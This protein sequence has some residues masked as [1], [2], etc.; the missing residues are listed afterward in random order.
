MSSSITSN[1]LPVCVHVWEVMRRARR[2][3][4]NPA[5]LLICS[6]AWQ[7]SSPAKAVSHKNQTLSQHI[8]QAGIS[9]ST[10]NSGNHS[11][12]L[13]TH[14]SKHTHKHTHRPIKSC[15]WSAPRECFC[16]SFHPHIFPLAF[17]LLQHGYPLTAKLT[18]LSL[19][20]LLTLAA[21]PVLT[22][23]SLP[24]SCPCLEVLS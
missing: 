11:Q 21:L 15:I 14:T 17:H 12:C 23:S 13:H 1:P 2:S 4:V 22:L 19:I 18:A 20:S 5:H 24:F 7:S 16:V 10:S 3:A 8:T 6:L 9:N